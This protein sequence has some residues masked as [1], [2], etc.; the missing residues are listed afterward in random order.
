MRRVCGYALT[1]VIDDTKAAKFDGHFAT[2]SRAGDSRTDP[3]FDNVG[4]YLPAGFLLVATLEQLPA[5]KGFTWS[6]TPGD[7]TPVYLLRTHGYDQI[8]PANV[9]A[10]PLP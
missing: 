6:M 10:M 7:D 8:V 4:Q 1:Q 9:A 3:N 5:T 2:G